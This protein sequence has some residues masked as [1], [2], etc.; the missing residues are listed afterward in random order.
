MGWEIRMLPILVNRTGAMFSEPSE[1]KKALASSWT[2]GVVGREKE[3]VQDFEQ[4]T[5]LQ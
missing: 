2:A 1:E 5:Y 3:P 4:A